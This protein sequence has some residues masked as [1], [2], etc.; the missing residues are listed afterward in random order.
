MRV[1]MQSERR[2]AMGRKTSK[3]RGLPDGGKTQPAIPPE[4]VREK[5]PPRPPEWR[6]YLG[7]I[8]RQWEGG[9]IRQSGTDIPR[10]E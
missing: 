10:V 1:Q 2:A 8:A 5:G 4:C 3:G 6:K 7:G 9:S